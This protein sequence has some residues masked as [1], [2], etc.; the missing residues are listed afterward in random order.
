MQITLENYQETISKFCS[1]LPL[2]AHNAHMALGM[3]SEYFELLKAINNNDTPNIIEESGDFCFFTSQYARQNRLQ[4]H[5]IFDRAMN[6]SG[7]GDLAP[8]TDIAKAKIA[9]YNKTFTYI[10]IEDALVEAMKLIL[11]KVHGVGKS[12]EDIL[13]INFEKLDARYKGK[14]FDSNNAVKRDLE[15]ERKILES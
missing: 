1:R 6:E 2:N 14:G 13:Q 5:I 10:Q 3:S 9:G 4:F 15:N 12:W 8:I 11:S 7:S